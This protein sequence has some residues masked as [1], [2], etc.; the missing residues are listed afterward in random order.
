[1]NKDENI[2]ILEVYDSAPAIENPDKTT[3]ILL[4][5]MAF[6]ALIIILIGETYAYFKEQ[7]IEKAVLGESVIPVY[8]LG[9]EIKVLD[10]DN[11]SESNPY[12]YQFAFSNSSKED[13]FI[14]LSLEERDGLTPIVWQLFSNGQE[15]KLIS[16]GI[17]NTD[18]E[19]F[20][21]SNVS[22]KANLTENYVLK[23]WVS[24]SELELGNSSTLE[25]S[26]KLSL[27]EK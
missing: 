7:A 2:E 25:T 18:E 3:K 23:L 16:S 1:M 4:I 12:L 21:T 20:L 9:E 8:P 10:L 26:L 6:L 17:W 14:S 13:V 5:V 15:E 22:S 11:T 27:V 19:I 24:N